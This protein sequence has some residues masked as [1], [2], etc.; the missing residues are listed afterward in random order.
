MVP[1]LSTV[2]LKKNKILLF[3][4][5][6]YLLYFF[7]GMYMNSVYHFVKTLTPKNLEDIGKEVTER[8]ESAIKLEQER[9][10]NTY[11]ASYICYCIKF[12][13]QPGL[14]KRFVMRY[15]IYQQFST[16]VKL[17]LHYVLIITYIYTII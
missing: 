12:K 13:T 1:Q 8:V 15:G 17:K 10:Q 14:L 16:K 9:A 7:I 4:F 2:N 5:Y 11:M 6:F 3:P